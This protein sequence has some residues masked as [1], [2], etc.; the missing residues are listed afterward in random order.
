MAGTEVTYRYQGFRG[1]GRILF[2]IWNSL[3]IK[4]AGRQVSRQVTMGK[5][6]QSAGP[7]GTKPIYKTLLARDCVFGSQSDK[8]ALH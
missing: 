6:F 2:A 7:G 4:A 5:K 8:A 3:V 1:L